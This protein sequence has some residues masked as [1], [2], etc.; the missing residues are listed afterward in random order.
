MKVFKWFDLIVLAVFLA[1]AVLSI[2]F[3]IK[4][5]GERVEIYKN[6]ELVKSESLSVDFVYQVDSH[7]TVTV[8][9]KQAFVSYSDCIG[10]DCV[11]AGKI[12]KSG[13]MI[14]CLPNKV[15]VKISG[16]GE[17]DVVTG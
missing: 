7:V 4:P 13:E 1:A 9:N 3:L 12:S 17:V 10:Q 16:K 5:V 14:T 2:C 6:G 8:S 11:S 15:I